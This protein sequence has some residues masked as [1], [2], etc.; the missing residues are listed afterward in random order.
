MILVLGVLAVLLA[1]L[2]S[3]AVTGP[4]RNMVDAMS[5][6][7]KE[8]VI[9]ELHSARKDEIGLLASSLN[10]MQSTIVANMRQLMRADK[11]SRIWHSMIP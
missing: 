8:Q 5:L 3:R 2:V 9:T 11:T 10:D 7:S 6:F 1:S 4:L